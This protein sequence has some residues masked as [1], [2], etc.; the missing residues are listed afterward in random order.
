MTF[1]ASRDNNKNVLFHG[2]LWKKNRKFLVLH[3]WNV[4]LCNGFL[5]NSN[6]RNFPKFL[7][8]KN[9]S[10]FSMEQCR[11]C[12]LNSSN[13]FS[14]LCMCV[15]SGFR[16]SCICNRPRNRYL[17]QVINNICGSNEGILCKWIVAKVPI[18]VIFCRDDFSILVLI[19][20][21]K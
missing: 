21:V 15:S 20:S 3:S 2:I 14:V 11:L 1:F 18:F 9:K 5:F 10:N 12:M 19:Q 4:G 8:Y 7:L 16:F 6:I 17:W 13:N